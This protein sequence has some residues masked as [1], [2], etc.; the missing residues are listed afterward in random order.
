MSNIG[1]YISKAKN[2]AAAAEERILAIDEMGGNFIHV[3]CLTERKFKN[4]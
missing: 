2:P 3:F 1:E 4:N